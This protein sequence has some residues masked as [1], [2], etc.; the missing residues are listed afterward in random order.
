MPK[1]TKKFILI[2][3]LL[4]LFLADVGVVLAQTKLDNPLGTDDPRV[5]VG[6]VIK[7]A[8]GI[9][10]SLA[11]GAFILGGFMWVISSGNDEKIKKGKDII[12]W[13][14]FGLAVIFTSYALVTFVINAVAGGDSTSGATTQPGSSATSQ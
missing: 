12:I 6:R 13:A 10:G 1:K 7:A 14:S 11:L 2:A 4:F 9:V 5:I 8:L 3:S